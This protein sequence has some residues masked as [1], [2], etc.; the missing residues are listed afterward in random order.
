MYLSWSLSV[1]IIIKSENGWG[2]IQVDV[3]TTFQV[4]AYLWNL[5]IH[6]QS[7]TT[8]VAFNGFKKSRHLSIEDK[9]QWC[10]HQW[11]NRPEEKNIA[12]TS[13]ICNT[14]NDNVSD[15]AK[16][17]VKANDRTC[18]GAKATDWA[19]SHDETSDQTRLRAKFQVKANDRTC[20]RLIETNW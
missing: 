4:G 2:H 11:C 16:F 7:A 6:T 9:F 3:I 18:L 19:Q 13:W 1:L 15:R 17:Q 12:T 20:L 10:P 5:A 14:E 8:G